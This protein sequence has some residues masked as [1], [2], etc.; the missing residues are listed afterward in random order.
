MKRK[1][2]SATAIAGIILMVIGIMPYFVFGANEELRVDDTKTPEEL[3]QIFLGSGMEIRNV[4]Y[5][6]HEKA[7]GTFQGGSKI[8]GFEEGIVLST[9]RA[10]NIVGPNKDHG[11]SSDFLLPGDEALS[12][13]IDGVKT[14]DAAVLE[15]DFIPE[16]DTITFTYVFASEEYNEYV[17]EYNDVF[18]F[19]VNGENRAL[20]PGT[21]IPVSINN[22]NGGKPLGAKPMNAEFFRN[23]ERD[24]KG[25][26][27]SINIE[28]DGLTTAMEVTAKVTPHAY[29]H[30]KLAI[31]DARDC[32]L[33]SAVLLK[34]GSFISEEPLP[35][36]DQLP[37]G[38]IIGR[39]PGYI[40]L[41]EP[42]KLLNPGSLLNLSYDIKVLE[43]NPNHTPRIYYWNGNKENWV[44]LTTYQEGK[45]LVKAVNDGGYSGWFT[46]LGVLEPTFKDE[47][48]SMDQD[49]INRMNGL[50]IVEGY[51]E[52][53]PWLS[54]TIMAEEP[55][56]RGEFLLFI[57]RILNIDIHDPKLPPLLPRE[58]ESILQHAFDDYEEIP[59]WLRIEA[60][61][62]C[63]TGLLSWQGGC[64]EATSPITRQEAAIMVCNALD[65]LGQGSGHPDPSLRPTEALTREDALSFIY[66][67]FIKGLGW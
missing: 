46:V 14:R 18:A 27:A 49:R 23:N 31:A 67:I 20:I 61:T 48:K 3:V 16:T 62:L 26:G 51:Y 1:H 63:E 47:G 41:G 22:V 2:R 33:D 13:L 36:T 11:I 53:G 60:G 24:K 7:R 17:N 38:T 42:Q 29:N 55:I 37:E 4:S 57:Y 39:M 43:K 30:I 45:G 35:P 44:A 12:D 65:Y 8:I 66:D 32:S 59:D 10:K 64:F 34:A 25:N 52:E 56:S 5:T 50:G 15:F 40:K 9:G 21:D 58:A 6:G 54:R 19:F 28:M